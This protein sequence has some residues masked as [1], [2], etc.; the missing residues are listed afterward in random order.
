MEN[1]ADS[2]IKEELNVRLTNVHFNVANIR[3]AHGFFERSYAHFRA[4]MS[5]PAFSIQPDG[6]LHPD[7][8]LYLEPLTL[9]QRRESAEAV[10]YQAMRLADLSNKV[11]DEILNIIQRHELLL[12]SGPPSTVLADEDITDLNS[13]LAFSNRMA[14]SVAEF[15]TTI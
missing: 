3:I 13:R 1:P 10:R 14:Q 12:K 2:K 15:L 4:Q 7:F 8:L 11:A 6:R 9:Q 5:R